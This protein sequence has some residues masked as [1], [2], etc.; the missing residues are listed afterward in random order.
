MKPRLHRF[1]SLVGQMLDDL[2]ISICVFDA[3]DCCQYWNHSLMR[4]FP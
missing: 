4:L 3:D 2:E 1:L